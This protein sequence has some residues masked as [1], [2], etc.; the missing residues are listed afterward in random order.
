M[1]FVL[2][3]RMLIYSCLPDITDNKTQP[4]SRFYS[5][6][7]NCAEFTPRRGFCQEYTIGNQGMG[8]DPISVQVS[9][10]RQKPQ[11]S[12]QVDTMHRGSYQVLSSV[13]QEYFFPRS[14]HHVLAKQSGSGATNM[15]DETSRVPVYTGS[16]PPCGVKTTGTL[17]SSLNF[18]P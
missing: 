12:K 5:I 11:A 16:P 18:K 10:P 15:A 6:V 13:S 9:I 2:G 1:G 8:T 7:L 3:G 14:G 4:L 17:I